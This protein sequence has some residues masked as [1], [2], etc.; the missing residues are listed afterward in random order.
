MALIASLELRPAR[1]RRHEDLVAR[2][3]LTNDG[4]D[5]VNVTLGPISSPSLCLELQDE[6][7]APVYLPPP[8][9]PGHPADTALI[10]AR[11]TLTV[12][13]PAFLPSWTPP[14]RFRARLRYI[15]PSSPA[16]IW[17]GE[18]HSDWIDF[19]LIAS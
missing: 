16:G 15:T 18:L 17:S 3:S 6:T 11:Q 9:V 2:C 5:P 19:E 8:P 13:H 10:E 14:G 7:G 4:E 12:E 1:A